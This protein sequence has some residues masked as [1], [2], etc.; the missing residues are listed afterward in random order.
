MEHFARVKV[1]DSLPQLVPVTVIGAG[2][3]KYRRAPKRIEL[4]WIENV[5][6]ANLS[7]LFPGMEVVEAHPFHVTRDGDIA[8]REL[9]AED[10]LETVEQGL[11][12]RRFGSVV[13]LAGRQGHAEARAEDPAE[14]LR[15]R[16]HRGLPHRWPAGTEAADVAS[17]TSTVPS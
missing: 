17:T 5:V 8:I 3:I 4:V 11:R 12:Q 1:P 7:A 9:E 13:R 14:Q 10:L 2:R 15:D 6:S 16:T